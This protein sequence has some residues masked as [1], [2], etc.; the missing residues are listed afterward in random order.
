MTDCSLVIDRLRLRLSAAARW[1]RDLAKKFPDD[2][3]NNRASQRLFELA[4]STAF[5][6]V[7][8]PAV[9][10]LLPHIES[11]AF[12]AAASSAARDIGFRK[13]VPDINGFVALVHEHLAE[14]AH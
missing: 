9:E 6:R 4:A 13:T 7:D 3:R 2:P 14:G 12:A 8:E 10:I 5:E 1:R 11:P